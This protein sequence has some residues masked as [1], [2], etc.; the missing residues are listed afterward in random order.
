[1][2]HVDDGALHA[3][4]DGELDAY[5]PRE[6]AWIRE[7]MEHCPECARRLEA[8]RAIR[9]EAEGILAGA[10]VDM[11]R[12]PTLEEMRARA[13]AQDAGGAG[14]AR[15]RARRMAWAASIILAAGAGWMANSL[16][17]RLQDGRD[18]AVQFLRPAEEALVP[19]GTGG[20]A[21]D[22]A[23]RSR[24]GE[25]EEAAPAAGPTMEDAA[26]GPAGEAAEMAQAPPPSPVAAEGAGDTPEKAAPSP[27]RRAQPETV[28]AE[29]TAVVAER[30]ERA[31]AADALD[32]PAAIQLRARAP[33]GDS[34][35]WPPVS[36]LAV[37]GLEILGVSF[38]APEDLTAG[39]RVMQRLPEGDTVAVYHLP[40][41]RSPADLPPLEEGES[42][43]AAPRDGGWVVIRGRL[44]A[45]ILAELG[46]RLP[47]G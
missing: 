32:V 4:L 23:M 10:P 7:H 28:S 11:G 40:P 33:A 42:Q 45:E 17:P 19:A 43:W 37:P 30:E 41:E 5:P 38:L 16:F 22:E 3:W 25:P 18:P 34:A 27:Q 36:Q 1:M 26:P 29:P 20:E 46:A 44:A 24:V 15:V 13:R 47:E 9:D 12:L 8:E 6:A 14:G 31:R 39:V 35:P 21:P 2:R